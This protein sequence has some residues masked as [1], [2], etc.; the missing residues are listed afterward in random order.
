M[1]QVH[2]SNKTMFNYRCAHC[3]LLFRTNIK[4]GTLYMHAFFF[5]YMR[6]IGDENGIKYFKYIKKSIIT[7]HELK[8]F[9]FF[10]FLQF[11]IRPPPFPTKRGKKANRQLAIPC[12]PYQFK[13]FNRFIYFFSPNGYNLCILCFIN[14]FY[15]CISFLFDIRLPVY[16]HQ[17]K[18]VFY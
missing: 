5:W 13:L 18:L 9:F 14:C 4:S 17:N 8:S 10:F 2:Y 16:G 1:T 11:R 15:V 7:M 12:L 3:K 6:K